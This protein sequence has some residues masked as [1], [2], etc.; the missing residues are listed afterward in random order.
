MTAGASAAAPKAKPATARG[1]ATL[2]RLLD[3]AEAEFGERGFHAASVS[4]ITARAKVSQGTFYIYFPSKEAIFGAVVRAIGHALRK[5]MAQ[6]SARHADRLHAQRAGLEAFL[7]FVQRHPGLYRIVQ[8]AQF[9]DEAAFREYYERLAEGYARS[10]ARDAAAGA[11]APGDAEVR[12]WA[13][14]GLGHFLGLRHCLWRNSLPPPQVLDAAMDF[15][16]SGI[17][18]RPAQTDR[19]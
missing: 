14:M 2:R 11:L 8:E 12:A 18:P 4:S 13:I 19:P 10:L 6:A 3:A 5:H 15:I 7:E 17:A 16:C 1:E 9:V